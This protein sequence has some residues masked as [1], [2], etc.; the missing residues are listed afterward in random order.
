MQKS[1]PTRKYQE[2]L[3]PQ[4]IETARVF[5]FF[6]TSNLGRQF[7]LGMPAVLRPLLHIH[8]QCWHGNVKKSGKI[9]CLTAIKP[10][11]SGSD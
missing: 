7:N 10:P 1:Y 11:L 2:K 4:L 3:C 6:E 5:S 8:G 9:S